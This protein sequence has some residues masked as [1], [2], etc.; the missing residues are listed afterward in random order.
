MYLI[1]SSKDLIDEFLIS[2]L[3]PEFSISLNSKSGSFLVALT[4]ISLSFSNAI[5]LLLIPL[6]ESDSL[7]SSSRIAGIF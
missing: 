3:A 5:T 4:H 6:E 2:F 1:V 7:S